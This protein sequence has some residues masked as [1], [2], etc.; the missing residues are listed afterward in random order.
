[1][2]V[3]G[4]SLEKIF[5]VYLTD[6]SK[7]RLTDCLRDA[8]NNRDYHANGWEG[9]D[10]PLQGDGWQPFTILDFETAARSTVPGI[11]ISNSCDI[12]GTNES[13]RQRN[14]LYA[15]LVRL[16]A[17]EG[18]LRNNGMQADRIQQ[19]IDSIRKQEKTDVFYV[20][21]GGS[22]PECVVLLDDIRSQPLPSFLKAAEGKKR[23]F[24]FNNFGFYM[25]L[26]KLSIHFTRF[27]EK[28][29]RDAP[30]A[31]APGNQAAAAG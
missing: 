18:M 7:A 21:A 1:M 27:G 14:V 22:I 19:H 10:Q 30:S 24:R 13:M 17:Y 3:D 4:E 9:P 2:A 20:P 5:P 29:D 6:A 26:M 23:L 11:V 12:D 31:N 25:F 8:A 16:E 28:L 15:P